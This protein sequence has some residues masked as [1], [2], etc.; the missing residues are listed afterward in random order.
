MDS[1]KKSSLP[2]WILKLDDADF[3]FI[4]EFILCSGSLKEL[5]KNYDV[6]YPTIRLRV[7]KLIDKIRL[8]DNEQDDSLVSLIKQLA[9]E[10]K[11][12]IDIAKLLICKYRE[13]RKS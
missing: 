11:I 8:F 12:D 9:I 10:D 3:K 13:E 1:N 6:S 2:N 4:K 5:A 7:D